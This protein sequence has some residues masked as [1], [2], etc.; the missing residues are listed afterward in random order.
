MSSSET[1]KVHVL[2]LDD[3]VRQA[4]R[5]LPADRFEVSFS[6]RREEALLVTKQTGCDLAIVELEAGGF[7]VVRDLRAR[8]STR[9]VAVVMVCER[10]H[11]RWLCLQAGAD[12]V[13]LKPLQ[14]V[15]TLTRAI[16]VVLEVAKTANNL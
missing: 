15:M 7:G 13:L 6:R 10:P 12:E 9:N 4:A 2:A 1:I 16:E 8:E 11:D 14:D 5:S 3:R